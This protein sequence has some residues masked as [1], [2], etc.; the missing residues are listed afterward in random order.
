[1]RRLATPALICAYLA[2]IV[3]ANLL[4]A[5]YGPPAAVLNALA[6]IGSDLVARDRLHTAWEGRRLW[7]RMLALIAA[8]GALSYALS[9]LT[10]APPQVVARIALASCAAFALAGVADAL[11]FQGLRGR[12]WLTR[13][14]GSNVAGATVD[15]LA[16]GL[17]VGLPWPVIALQLL[18]KAAGGAAWAWALRPRGEDAHHGA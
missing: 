3:A 13:A 4:L 2:A 15:S 7:P 16:F 10:P 14:N 9:W 11:A 8:G 18:A 12:P 6:L 5:A 1:M 17:G